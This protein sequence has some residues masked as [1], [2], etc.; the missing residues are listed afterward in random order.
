MCAEKI[1]RFLMASVI[2]LAT[3]LIYNGISEAVYLLMFVVVMI[4]IW[5][6]SDFCP[7]LYVIKKI[8]VKPC[9][10]KLENK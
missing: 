10:R 1:H 4:V 5:G 6:I 7:S 9:Y 3:G 8:G 2:A